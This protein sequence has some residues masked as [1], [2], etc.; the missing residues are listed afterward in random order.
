MRCCA[1]AQN[2]TGV[3]LLD[4]A[5]AGGAAR[6]RCRAIHKCEIEN[7]PASHALWDAKC[8]SPQSCISNPS[9]S[10]IVPSVVHATTCSILRPPPPLMGENLRGGTNVAAFPTQVVQE[11]QGTSSWSCSGFPDFAGRCEGLLRPTTTRNLTPGSFGQGSAAS[12][13]CIASASVCNRR[14]L[15]RSDFA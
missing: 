8:A 4:F 11:W 2:W 7:R 14:A 9:N 1:R 5:V 3:V 10:S 12:C 6:C 15:S 13:R